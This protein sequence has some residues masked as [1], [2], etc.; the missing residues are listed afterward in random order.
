MKKIRLLLISLVIT[1]LLGACGSDSATKEAFPTPVTNPKAGEIVLTTAG[2]VPGTVV[3][4]PED[5]APHNNLTEWWYYTGHIITTDGQRYGFEYVTFQALRSILPPLYAAHFAITDPNHKVFK[6]EQT[7]RVGDK[8]TSGGS[9]GFD[10]MT[11]LGTMRG[12]NGVDYLKATMKKETGQYA[13]DFVVQETQGVALHGGGQFTYGPGG[14]SYYYSRPR[15]TPTGTITVDGQTKTV[16]EGVVWFDH[17][18]GDFIPMGGG[19]DWFSTQLDDGTSLMLYQLRDDQGK[20]LQVFGSYIPFCQESCQ[21]NKPLKVVDLGLDNIVITPTS[22]WVSPQTGTTY[23]STWNVK[24]KANPQK[25]IPEL[26]LNYKPTMP[27]QELDT[28][29]STATIYWEGDTII[30]GT[31]NGKPINGSGYVE[32]TGYS[33]TY[34]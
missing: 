10:L 28:R 23:P 31:K 2:P 17:Q 24:I 18:W 16:K 26:E 20:L 12:L 14:N 21:S 7:T 13:I 8:L 6:V 29:A 22:Q 11:S 15:M 1:G 9:A 4:F 30:A 19:W 5:E 25:A 34:N 27:N 32:L 3:K 33:K